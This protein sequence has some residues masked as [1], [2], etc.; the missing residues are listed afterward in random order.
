MYRRG[1]GIGWLMPLVALGAVFALLWRR[2]A[3]P[4]SPGGKIVLRVAAATI[5]VVAVAAGVMFAI[6]TFSE[7]DPWARWVTACFTFGLFGLPTSILGIVGGA[8][9]VKAGA[10]T[11][12]AHTMCAIFLAVSYF[13]Q[14]LFLAASLLRRSM[15]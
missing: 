9:L 11:D 3:T 4:I 6:L 8:I 13:A 2:P 7:S 14:W 10:S 5:A 12:T 15:F 1:W